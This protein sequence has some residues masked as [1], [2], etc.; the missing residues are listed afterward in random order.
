MQIKD[1]LIVLLSLFFISSAAAQGGIQFEKGN[2]KSITDLAKKENKIIFMDAYTTW[3]GPCKKMSREIFPK[4]N[5]GNFY[6]E[7]F[8]NVKMDMEKGDGIALGDK[9]GVIAYPTL[10]FINHDGTLIHRVAGYHN[11][12]EFLNLAAVALDPQRNMS[13]LANRYANGDRDPDFL[14]NYAIARRDAMDGSH[15]AIAKAYLATQKDWNTPQNVDF[16]FNFCEDTDSELFTHIIENK[17]VYI[18]IF[19]ENLVVGKIQELV[20]NKLYATE[21]LSLDQVKSLFGKAYPEKAEQLTS[22]YRMTFYRQKGDRKGFS[23]AAFDH[24]KRYPSNDPSELNDVA[25]TFYEAINDKEA[26]K[27]AV[28]LCKKSIKLD[29]AYYNTDTLAAL[30]Y[31]LGKKRKALKTAKKAIKL[32]K[33]NQE[34][35]TLSEELIKK[36]KQL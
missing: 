14:Y 12:T 4:K 15:T 33:Q 5:V 11:E 7:N 31:K 22:H 25:W 2:W 13:A 3:C 35:Y 34:D 20:Y 9:Y 16:I 1:S 32:A 24:Y 30:Y 18:A 8:I 26:L 19:D 6:N 23:D 36:I 27:G 17:Q 28:A 21:N 10:L 29:K